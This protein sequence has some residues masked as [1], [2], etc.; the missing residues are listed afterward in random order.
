MCP[1]QVQVVPYHCMTQSSP[2]SHANS[3]GGHRYP[4]WLA[5]SQAL[6]QDVSHFIDGSGP[7][8]S[9]YLERADEE[10][11]KMAENWKADAEGILIFVRLYRLIS[12]FTWTH[13]L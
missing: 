2:F 10:D 1:T 11:R 3:I 12:C 8:F 6:A 9:M 13:R 4:H 7:I 5:Q